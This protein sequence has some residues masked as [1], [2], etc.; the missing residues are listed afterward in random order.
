MG[1]QSFSCE[2]HTR[3]EQKEGASTDIPRINGKE[4]LQHAECWHGLLELLCIAG[5]K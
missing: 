2:C 4:L 1:V 5:S 3:V